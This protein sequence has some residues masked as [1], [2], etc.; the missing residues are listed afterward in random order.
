MESAFF[1]ILLIILLFLSGYFSATETALFSLPST[2]IKTFQT[3]SSPRKRLIAQLVLKPRDLLVT[4]FMLNTFVNILIQ[5]TSS[6]MYGKEASWLFKVVLPFFLMLIIGEIIP[7]NFGLQNNVWFAN[8]VA[9]SINLMQNLLKPI[10]ALTIMITVPVSR[11]MFFYLKPDESISKDELKHV[12]ATSQEFGVLHPDEAELLWG[13]LKLQDATVKMLMR[14]RDHILYYD[15]QEPLSKLIYL[16]VDQKCSRLPVC[17]GS[18]D[19]VIGITTTR[20][21]LLH[22][23][24]IKSGEDMKKFLFAPLYIPENTPA[25]SL[26]LRLYEQ[27]Q[28]LAMV[29]DEYGSITGLITCEDLIEEVI[30]DISDMRDSGDQ[31]TK[32]GPDEIIANGRMELSDFNDYFN[33]HLTSEN[34]MVTLGGWL[35]EKLGDIPKN[36][37]K[38]D[39]ENFKFHILSADLTKIRRVYVRKIN[40]RPVKK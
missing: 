37:S 26:F 28:E 22:R 20:H 38:Y 3:S 21:F 19:N 31:F 35:I 16:F 23:H 17:E 34:N 7:K 25:K 27:N 36:G 15:I 40:T 6:A 18:L 30:G 13:Y 9:P 32:A 33:V 11:I 2:K 10:R 12:L 1:I 29:V 24:E 5:N 14:P 8:L 4:V 39:I